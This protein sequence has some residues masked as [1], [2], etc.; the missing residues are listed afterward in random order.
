MCQHI[1]FPNHPQ[2][3]SAED[4]ISYCSNVVGVRKGMGIDPYIGIGILLSKYY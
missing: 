3:L 4:A 1:E 2:F